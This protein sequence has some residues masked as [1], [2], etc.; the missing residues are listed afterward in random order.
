MA[1]GGGGGGQGLVTLLSAGYGRRTEQTREISSSRCSG[2]CHVQYTAGSLSH[3]DEFRAGMLIS[4][5]RRMICW[6]RIDS[7]VHLLFFRSLNSLSPYPSHLFL[8]V[9]LSFLLFLSL[10][11]CLS[12][13]VS[14]E[15]SSV[16]MFTAES[17][18]VYSGTGGSRI[19]VELSRIL[20]KL[21]L[22]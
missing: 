19:V 21:E 16:A 22:T 4:T 12:N 8:S 2:L 10:C 9:C 13:C 18:S 15:T 1:G 11:L 6:F 5:F 20:E 17:K 7:H 14:A 3:R